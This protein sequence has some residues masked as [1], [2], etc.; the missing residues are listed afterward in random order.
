MTLQALLFPFINLS[1]LFGIGCLTNLDEFI[2]KLPGEGKFRPMGD[3][4]HSYKKN[5]VEYE[6]YKVML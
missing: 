2:A 6:I 3:L 4:L 5:D 1:S